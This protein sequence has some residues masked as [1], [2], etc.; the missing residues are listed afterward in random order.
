MFSRTQACSSCSNTGSIFQVMEICLSEPSNL[1]FFS[2]KFSRGALALF[3]GFKTLAL[4]ILSPNNISFPTSLKESDPTFHLPASPTSIG[5]TI[6]LIVAWMQTLTVLSLLIKKGLEPPGPSL[7]FL[8]YTATT[9]KS[10]AKS[11]VSKKWVLVIFWLW[12]K[13]IML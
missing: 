8:T 1:P 6:I 2:L 7:S 3:P 12:I 13:P 11:H 9:H 5:R 4:Q 10:T